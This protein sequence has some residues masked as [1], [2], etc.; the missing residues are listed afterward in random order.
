MDSLVKVITPPASTRLTTPA[1]AQAECAT[2]SDVSVLI[3]RASAVIVRYCGRPFG[4]QTVQETFRRQ[5]AYFIDTWLAGRRHVQPLVLRYAYDQT[6]TSVVIDDG[7]PLVADTDYEIDLESGMLWRL[8]SG[9]RQ[10]WQCS[11]SIVIE[12]ETGFALPNDSDPNLPD[13]VEAACLALVRGA[14]NYIGSDPTISS[15]QTFQVGTTNYFARPNSGLVMDAG[16]T[17]ALSGYVV[18]A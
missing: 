6:P 10:R 15:D 2:S 14:F 12:Y 16:L 9:I 8:F 18:R 3:D 5:H 4:L 11:T 17:E 13:D 7:D 1:A